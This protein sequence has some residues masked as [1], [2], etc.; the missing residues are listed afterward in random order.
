MKTIKDSVT[1]F[2]KLVMLALL[3]SPITSQ[4]F[5]VICSVIGLLISILA[6]TPVGSTIVATDLS[7]FLICTVVG[8]IK[9]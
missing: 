8:K 1:I 6:G 5:S 7:I 4:C 9:R 2:Q 3:I